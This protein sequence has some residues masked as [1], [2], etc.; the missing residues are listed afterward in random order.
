MLN[1]LFS[2]LSHFAEAIETGLA[3][4]LPRPAQ[5]VKSATSVSCRPVK[6]PVRQELFDQLCLFL[7][8]RLNTGL[9]PRSY[10]MDHDNQTDRVTRLASVLKCCP[11]CAAR[12]VVTQVA[13]QPKFGVQCN[14]CPLT[15]PEV[16][17]TPESAIIAWS[18]RRGTVSS[19]GGRGT[20]DKCSWRKRRSCR[21]NLRLAR[22]R[23]KKK[24]ITAKLLIMLPWV[25]ALRK[26]ERAESE[27]ERVR[28]WASL[29]AMK[30]S[31]L[32]VP[33]LR[34]VWKLFQNY[35]PEEASL[36]TPWDGSPA[37][38]QQFCSV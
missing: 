20:R 35:A 1:R 29:K 25:Q 19:A 34:K 6:H 7:S 5:C 4:T 30:S 3:A 36:P 22:K 26:F 28:A 9:Q 16:Y 14:G 2:Q 38:V 11:C 12:G 31:V 27:E 15:F 21:K 8:W 17:S 23:K 33:S 10:A 13:G 24:Q 18:L 32:S 37:F